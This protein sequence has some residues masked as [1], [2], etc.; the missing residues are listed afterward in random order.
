MYVYMLTDKNNNV[1]Y[2]GVTNDLERR[3][4]EHRE[5]LDDGFT[6]HYN[7][8]K[9]VYAESWSSTADAIRREK[10]LKGWRRDKKDALI[11]SLNPDWKEL[12][13]WE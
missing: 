1:L 13:P 6:A 2:V 3:I 4:R 9:L 12:M 5:G 10:Q 7:L 11:A 8:N